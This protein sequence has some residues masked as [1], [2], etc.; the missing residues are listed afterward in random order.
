MKFSLDVS[1]P[2]MTNIK[3]CESV[4]IKRN[5][6]CKFRSFSLSDTQK[7][8]KRKQLAFWISRFCTPSQKNI[9]QRIFRKSTL[10]L[11]ALLACAIK[12]EEFYICSRNEITHDSVDDQGNSFFQRRKEREEMERFQDF[13]AKHFL[14]L[15]CRWRK[16][17]S[18]YHPVPIFYL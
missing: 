7:Q 14:D 1:W 15:L 17:Y 6:D 8:D 2:I 18:K 13:W 3:H 10:E 9:S 12:W 11:T 4:Y 5:C 16:M